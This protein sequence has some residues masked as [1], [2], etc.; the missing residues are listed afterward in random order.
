MTIVVKGREMR[1]KIENLIQEEF[2]NAIVTHGFNHSQHEGASVLLEEIEEL[3]EDLDFI[4]GAYDR[5]WDCVKNDDYKGANS[6]ADVIAR[7]TPNTVLE[8]IQ[9]GAMARKFGVEVDE[10]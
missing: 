9:V 6:F 5:L 3:E 4:K 1:N 8:A 10:M 2:N 7:R